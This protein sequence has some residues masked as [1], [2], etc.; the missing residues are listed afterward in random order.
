MNG[1]ERQENPLFRRFE[2]W[3]DWAPGEFIP[4][5]T[6]VLY[7]FFVITSYY[8]LK[9][10]RESLALELGASR[11]PA[12]NIFS[13]FSL[14]AANA[15]YSWIVGRF[16]RDQFI[17]WITRG[18]I[19]SLIGFWVIF[20]DFVQKPEAL[21]QPISSVR[22]LAI[23]F[24]FI[25]V[26]LFGL[27]SVSMFWSFVNDVFTREQGQRLYGTIGFGGLVGGLCGGLITAALVNILGTA[28]MFL[29]AAIL[30]EPSVWCMRL[31]SGMSPPKTDESSATIEPASETH[32][33]PEAGAWDG[34]KR[35]IG[36]PFLGLM[37]LEM[38]LYTFG[39]T[40]FSY[41]LNTIMETSLPSRDGRTM[42]WANIYNSI[43]ALSILSQALV[44]GRVMRSSRPW[45][46]LMLMPLMQM[47]GSIGLL[48]NPVL[49]LAAGIGIVRYA[50]NYSTGRA[51]RELFFTP[52]SR[53]DKYQAK[54][55]ID[56]FVFR[57]GDGIASSLL[58]SWLVFFPP[59]LWIDGAI[60]GTMTCS[61]VAVYFL[62]NRFQRL[63]AKVA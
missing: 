28:K 3:L 5:A 11:I 2:R 56:T 49:G 33:N 61:L 54:G 24:Y 4:T 12:L 18:F 31:I 46:G 30:L 29:V 62:G 60:L 8:V 53:E 50:L 32:E 25:W 23:G 13:M 16:H 39:S 19:V 43:N 52:L 21:A 59:R 14:L 10:I 20:G 42:Y 15:G 63:T 7:F 17:P 22:I 51:V 40:L 38:F 57:M 1:T 45:M 36:N 44:T 41:Q 37:A 58:L 47:V 55:F 27:F 6:A 9:P 34:L 48:F 35:T 26:N